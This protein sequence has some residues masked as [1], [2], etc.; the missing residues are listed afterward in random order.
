MSDFHFFE[1]LVN[2]PI[3]QLKLLF[4]EPLPKIFDILV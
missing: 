2:G 4:N 3:L 1:T